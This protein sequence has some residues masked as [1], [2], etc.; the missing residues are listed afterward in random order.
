MILEILAIHDKLSKAIIK[1]NQDNKIG[2]EKEFAVRVEHKDADKPGR[3][4]I[5][6]EVINST[7]RVIENIQVKI[8]NKTFET[9]FIAS[10]EI[11]T[12]ELFTVIF[13]LSGDYYIGMPYITCNNLN[14]TKIEIEVGKLS[15]EYKA[16]FDE[17]IKGLIPCV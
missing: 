16:N 1:E 3:K 6:L 2:K 4:V 12:F 8:N 9:G 13:T 17:Y 11:K 10:K 14:D 5:V 7:D 15:Y